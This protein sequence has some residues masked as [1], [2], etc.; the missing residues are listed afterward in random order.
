[1]ILYKLWFRF[2][3][4]R[5]LETR[6]DYFYVHDL[7]SALGLRTSI[8]I[9]IWLLG[10]GF[11]RFYFLERALSSFEA[12][13]FIIV[14]ILVSEG[15]TYAAG[16]ALQKTVYILELPWYLQGRSVFISGHNSGGEEAT[17][18]DEHQKSVE[19]LKGTKEN[20]AS[21]VVRRF[22]KHA[23]KF[24]VLKLF[25]KAVKRNGG[26]SDICK[27]GKREHIGYQQVKVSKGKPKQ[28]SF[29]D[30]CKLDSKE[31]S[32]EEG[33]SINGRARSGNGQQLNA[34]G[35]RSIEFFKYCAPSAV[36]NNAKGDSGFPK[37][38]GE[39]WF[40]PSDNDLP[41]RN[42]CK[43]ESRSVAD[44]VEENGDITCNCERNY[45]YQ[46]CRHLV[47]QLPVGKLSAVMKFLVLVSSPLWLVHL[48][49]DRR[50]I[51]A[52]SFVEYSKVDNEYSGLVIEGGGCSWEVEK[53]AIVN[54]AASGIW[55]VFAECIALVLLQRG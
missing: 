18:Q 9:A 49:F 2:A 35:G 40:A 6:R 22:I 37:P 32:D 5:I 15:L 50:N 44:F 25:S 27:G 10:Y 38:D 3:K 8:L 43:G 42:P 7:C 31:K 55:G 53:D 1:M 14:F 36:G 34:P 28:S 11:L 23:F 46:H 13:P 41:D 12:I 52:V 20:S 24:A 51:K 45:E 19:D 21:G 30:T 48:L 54:A 16:L 4:K 26:L 29:S 33:Q 17:K 39:D 47:E